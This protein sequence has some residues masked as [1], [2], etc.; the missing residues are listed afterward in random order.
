M[1]VPELDAP[2]VGVIVPRYR[3]SAVARNLVKRRLRELVRQELLPHLRGAEIVLRARPEAYGATAAA[4]REDL[5]AG[6][7]RV[8]RLTERAREATASE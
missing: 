8:L 1:I 2:R 5:C 4:L 3:Q 6:R 7:A